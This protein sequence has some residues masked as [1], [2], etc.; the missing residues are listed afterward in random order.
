MHFYCLPVRALLPPKEEPQTPPPATDSA[1]A[2]PGL[3]SKM[4][5]TDAFESPGCNF[6]YS[7]LQGNAYKLKDKIYCNTAMRHAVSPDGRFLIYVAFPDIVLFDSVAQTN[8]KLMSVLNNTDGVDFYWSPD[9][10]TI[11][12]PVVNQQDPTYTS[13]S[14]TKAEIWVS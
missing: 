13:S 3:V 9:S 6:I 10:R 8:T 1:P 4:V 14:G 7:D 12:M 5:D 2:L 11:A